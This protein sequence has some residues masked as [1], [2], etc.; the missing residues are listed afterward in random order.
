MRIINQELPASNVMNLFTKASHPLKQFVAAKV[1]RLRTQGFNF[2]SFSNQ[3]E[4]MV[5]HFLPNDN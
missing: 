5:V 2:N 1:K 3:L 4:N